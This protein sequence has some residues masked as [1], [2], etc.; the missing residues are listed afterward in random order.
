MVHRP[1][2]VQFTFS[3]TSQMTLLAAWPSGFGRRQLGRP[4]TTYIDGYRMLWG[5]LRGRP[6]EP[7]HERYLGRHGSD[8]PRTQEFPS[9]ES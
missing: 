5:L 7:Q 6:L 2:P 8:L 9:W 3:A 1:Q 4:T